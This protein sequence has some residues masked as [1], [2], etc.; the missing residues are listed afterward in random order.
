M[1]NV[2]KLENIKSSC[3]IPEDLKDIGKIWIR[4]K[5]VCQ[6]LGIHKST[7]SKY[8]REGKITQYQFE[9]MPLYDAAE[10]DAKVKK[11][12]LKKWQG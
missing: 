8:V 9:G 11:V 3:A 7:V 2:I 5:Q 12:E 4:A 6:K 1:Q 10:I